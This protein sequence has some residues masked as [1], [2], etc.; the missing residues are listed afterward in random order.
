[1]SAATPSARQMAVSIDSGHGPLHGLLTLPAQASALVV[2]AHA[3]PSPEARDEALAVILRHA[4]IG[5]LTLDLLTPSEERFEDN[6]HNVPQLAKR[7]LDGL[8]L[9]KQRML[10]DELPKLPIGLCAAG[11]C[12]PVVLRVAAQR[13][14]DIFAIVCRG[15]LIDLAGMMYLH[16]LASP[17]LVLVGQDDERRV[18]STR[19][20]LRELACPN[21]L[22]LLPASADSPDSGEDFES[23]ARETAHWFVRHLP[24]TVAAATAPGR[25]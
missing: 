20:A 15:G 10:T 23:V 1:M 14:H 12:S 21:E 5:T 18:V 4:R 8:L 2:L 6:H 25:A 3:G 7:L 19:R 16:L 17:L 9:I 11:D 13:D 24:T 22:Q